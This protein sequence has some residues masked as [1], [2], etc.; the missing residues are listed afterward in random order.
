MKR[1][2]AL[3]CLWISGWAAAGAREINPDSVAILY[4]SA[5]PEARQLAEFYRKARNIPEDNV[6]GLEMP[7]AADISR[8]DYVAKIQKP[9]RY[10]FERRAWWSRGEDAGGLR[11]P[12]SNDIR[13]LVLIRGVPLRIQQGPVPAGFTPP[14]NDPVAGRNEASVDSELAMV[15]VEGT[16]ME[17]ALKNA[18][19]QSEKPISEAALPFLMLTARIDGASAETCRRMITDAIEAEKT[20]LW[21]RA[22]ID[23]SQKYP[24]GDQWLEGIAAANRKTGIPTVVDRFTDTFPLNYP[25]T[26]AAEYYGWYDWNLSGPF[27][28]PAFRF[29]KG[30]VAMHLHSFSAEQLS[31]PAKNWSAGLL[32]KGAAVTIGNVYEPYLHLTHNFEI[33]HNRLLAGNTW[34]EA[35][36]MSIMVTSWQAVVLGDPLYRPFLHLDGGGDRAE[37]DND[38]R[39]L[40]AATV[41]WPTDTAERERQLLAAAER[42]DSGI[43]VEAVGLS[44]VESDRKAEAAVYFQNA[45]PRYK[46]PADKLRQDFNLIAIQRAAGEKDQAIRSLRS[47]A[48]EPYGN[49]PEAVAA[50]G[51][52]DILDPPAP[53]QAVPPK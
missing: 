7:V 48:A 35:C 2:V 27:L 52:L 16:P 49:I 40:R 53:P 36:W 28:N 23:L 3:C 29:R 41:Q 19:Y 15:G 9:L 37:A 20:G 30:A 5:A 10:E 1:I 51:W 42:M 11:L 25:M 4:N 39:A 50:K 34:V 43:L 26:D 8:A 46:N 47:I 21:G 13:V 17:G 38:Y 18:Y 24:M 6:I 12:T 32:E 33:L 45:K 44:A 14:A 31:D 22:Y